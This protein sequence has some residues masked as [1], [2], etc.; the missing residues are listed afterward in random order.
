MNK[1]IWFGDGEI[2]WGD[3]KEFI[4]ILSYK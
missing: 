2:F 1:S 4:L 3:G